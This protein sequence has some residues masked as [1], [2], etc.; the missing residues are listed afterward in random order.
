MEQYRRIWHLLDR[1]KKEV[2][3]LEFKSLES[4]HP[5]FAL[6]YFLVFVG[7]TWQGR[8]HRWSPLPCLT[9]RSPTRLYPS[10]RY[11]GYG[12]VT[13]HVFHIWYFPY[14]QNSK[15][16]PRSAFLMTWLLWLALCAPLSMILKSNKMS[17]VVL[18][19]KEE[20]TVCSSL[21]IFFSPLPTHLF[22]PWHIRR[23]NSFL[24]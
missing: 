17:E 21:C 19:N 8:L 14:Y 9:H 20:T 6:C 1:I 22:V 7:S 3:E 10:G 23:L 2:S 13:Y 11:I 18:A 5:H 4:Q 12:Q 24:L 15:Y 16:F